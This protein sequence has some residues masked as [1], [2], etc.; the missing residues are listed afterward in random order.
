MNRPGGN[1]TG[2]NTLVAELS[3]KQ[4]GLLRDI[5]P[6]AATIAVL[7]E[8][9]LRSGETIAL[10]L[11]DARDATAALGQKLLVLEPSTADEIDAQFASLDRTGGAR[12]AGRIF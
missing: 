10:A 7:V 3:G 9:S 5:V 12:L 8:P 4:L 2:V 6:K 1:V 11:T